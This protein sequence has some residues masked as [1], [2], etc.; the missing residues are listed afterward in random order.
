M[1]GETLA[2]V[3]DL[4]SG[5]TTFTRFLVNSLGIDARVQSPTFVIHRIYT[6]GDGVVKKVHHLDLYRMN[7]SEDIEDLDISEYLG[8]K[9]SVT[10][11]EWPDLIKEKLPGGTIFIKF[12]IIDENERELQIQNLHR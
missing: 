3:G 12:S 2:L 5:K 7:S 11:I 8:E 4:G 9:D 6:G 1:G 10:I